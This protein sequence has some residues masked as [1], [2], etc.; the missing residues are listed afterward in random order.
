[1][2]RVT[3][4]NKGRVT[5][6]VI[7]ILK[8]SNSPVIIDPA[9]KGK[10]HRSIVATIHPKFVIAAALVKRYTVSPLFCVPNLNDLGD[11]C[12]ADN[13][14]PLLLGNISDIFRSNSVAICLIIP[15]YE[16]SLLVT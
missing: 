3:G 11:T 14:P 9:M 1:M 8:N 10:M 2:K 6:S 13:V 16:L 15:Q 7:S 12:I 5:I 4:M